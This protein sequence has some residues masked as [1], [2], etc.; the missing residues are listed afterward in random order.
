MDVKSDL[1][2]HMNFKKQKN[3]NFHHFSII[4]RLKRGTSRGT[5]HFH[6]AKRFRKFWGNPQKH[7]IQKRILLGWGRRDFWMIWPKGKKK[8][9]K[10]R[11]ARIVLSEI[12]ISSVLTRPGFMTPP[13]LRAVVVNITGDIIWSSFHPEFHFL[14]LYSHFRFY[15]NS[16]KVWNVNI[17]LKVT[18]CT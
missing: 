12:K 18:T 14:K 2:H 1:K 4:L 6:Y 15:R 13:V 9:L 17:V 3:S 16:Y 8:T 5:L 11:R 10:S 7:Y